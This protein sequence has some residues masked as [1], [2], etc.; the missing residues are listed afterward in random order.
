M[1]IQKVEATSKEW[2]GR[3]VRQEGRI[4]IKQC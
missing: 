2:K 1:R 3:S 4:K